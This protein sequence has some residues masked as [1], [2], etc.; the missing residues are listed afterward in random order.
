MKEKSIK[1]NYIL[2]LIKTSSS[3]FFS[4][5]TFAYAS[6][7]LSVE[8][9]GRVDFS[10]S[11]ISYFT[12]FAMLGI[13]HYG[14]R[15]GAKVRNNRS[16]LTK[17]TKELLI[18]NG[19]TTVAAYI[20]F[21][22]V[23]AGVS[24]I[25]E[26]RFTLLI[27]SGEIAFTAMGLEWLYGALEEYKYVTVRY[28]LFQVISLF[29]LFIFV[30]D[31]DSYNQYACILLFS[32]VGSNILNFFHARKFIDFKI[33]TQIEIQ[34]HIG[35]V[36]VFFSNALVGS[37]YFTLDSSMLGFMSTDYAVGLYSAA[38]KINRFCISIIRSLSVV[39]LPRVS[40]YISNGE[41]ERYKFLLKRCFDCVVMLALPAACGMFLMS[42]NTI[43][44]FSGKEFLPAVNCSKL[45]S[46]MVL[47][48]PLSAIATNQVLLPFGKE[49]KNLLGTVAGIISNLFVNVLLIPQH[50][51]LGAALGTVIAEFMICIILWLFAWRCLDLKFVFKN[52]WHY[53]CSSMVMVTIVWLLGMFT[54]GVL[55]CILSVVLGMAVYFAV[56][57]ILRD[58][59]FLYIIETLRNFVVGK[60]GES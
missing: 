54:D 12:T 9:I 27:L 20:C 44:L 29:F 38:N 13:T 56:L 46:I 51:E 6:R 15:E 60:F 10:K 18:I 48:V 53:V 1:R 25:Q 34:R 33:K 43:L 49:R 55:N 4:V 42:E 30:Q 24:K 22:T 21:F 40:Y 59:F 2:Q 14:I 31:V 5:I 41:Y 50:G 19:V 23:L 7:V 11:I 17:L 45:M 36:L 8:G 52:S 47:F 37:I 3:L 28:I 16:E 39:L 58:D 26:Y 32:T 35:P 57:Y